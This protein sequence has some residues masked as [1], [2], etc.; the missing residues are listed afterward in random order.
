MEARELVRDQLLVEVGGGLALVRQDQRLQVAQHRHA[1]VDNVVR[2]VQEREQHVLRH[3][4][5]VEDVE[6]ALPQPGV[7]HH[8]HGDGGEAEGGVEGSPEVTPEATPCRAHH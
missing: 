7:Q 2:A 4:R 3:L 6:E 8:G 5:Q 1:E